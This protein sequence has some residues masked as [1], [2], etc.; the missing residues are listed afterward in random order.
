LTIV[1]DKREQTLTVELEPQERMGP[2]RMM[3][4]T[5]LMGVD[6]VEMQ[7]IAAEAQAHAKEMEAQ[8]GEWQKEH[9]ELQREQQRLQEE[10]Q[11]LQ[12]EL[13]KQIER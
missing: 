7:E 13:P 11:R 1:R 4:R 10:M 2:R 3:T 9:Q 8:A 12:Q 6:P 5:E